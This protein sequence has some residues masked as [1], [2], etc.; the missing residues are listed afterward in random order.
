MRPSVAHRSVPIHVVSVPFGEL[1]VAMINCPP[2]TPLTV[3][4]RLPGRN[5][6][7]LHL[8]VGGAYSRTGLCGVPKA[9]SPPTTTI[10]PS[11]TNVPSLTCD[12][13]AGRLATRDHVLDTVSYRSTIE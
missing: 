11:S 1:P 3:V 7:V 12:R 10:R 4:L 5:P 13:A 2:M 8:F 6:I 9:V